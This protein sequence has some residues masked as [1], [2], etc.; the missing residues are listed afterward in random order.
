MKNCIYL[1]G[2]LSLACCQDTQAQPY[3]SM[4]GKDSTAWVFK[5]FNL[6]Q[7]NYEQ[8]HYTKDTTINGVAY[9][10]LELNTFSNMYACVLR[11]DVSQGKV[12]Y[13]SLDP[14][15]YDSTE[16]L[17]F[18]FSLEVGDTF[19]V[20][21]MNT[22]LQTPLYRK[23]DS[24]T[25]IDGL[26]YIYFDLEF[27]NM[28]DPGPDVYIAPNEPLTLIEGIGSNMGPLYKQQTGLLRSQYLMCSYKDGIQT[29]YENARYDGL[30]PDLGTGIREDRLHTDAGLNLYP[31]PASDY[32][33]ISGPLN[34]EALS[35]IIYDQTGRKVKE[36]GQTTATTPI[37]VRSLPDGLYYLKL[38]YKNEVTDH[39]KLIIQH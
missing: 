17:A 10:K 32:C 15:A 30:C 27:I 2:F 16:Y 4:F 20:A 26:K 35:V 29:S 22:G 24:I 5:W 34:K 23:V 8:V 11:E 3:Q 1:L 21:N 12:W 28:G 6:D 9:K 7:E 19:N 25:Y 33:S 14:E 37:D 39:Q 36:L 13:R 31:N 38:I 18:D